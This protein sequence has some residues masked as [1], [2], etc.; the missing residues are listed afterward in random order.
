MWADIITGVIVIVLI[1]SIARYMLCRMNSMEEKFVTQKEREATLLKNDERYDR[2]LKDL[3]KGD[4]KFTMIQEALTR[5]GELLSSID[6]SI[7]VYRDFMRRRCKE[8]D[9]IG[10]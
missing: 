1:G 3:D 10:G 6:S 7:A 2:I 9:R 8:M 4:E 5:H